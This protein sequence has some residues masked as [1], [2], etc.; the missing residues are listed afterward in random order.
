M[1]GSVRG[2]T[3]SDDNAAEPLKK[4]NIGE[5]YIDVEPYK[6]DETHRIDLLHETPNRMDIRL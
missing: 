5:R 6:M 2:F 1:S 4:N 3:A